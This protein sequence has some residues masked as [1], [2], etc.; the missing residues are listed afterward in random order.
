MMMMVIRNKFVFTTSNKNVGK[1]IRFDLNFEIEMF[2]KYPSDVIQSKQNGSVK[3]SVLCI[4][5][6][7]MHWKHRKKFKIFP[8]FD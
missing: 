8:N 7:D 3:I 5:T 6:F 1:N 2:L 4:S